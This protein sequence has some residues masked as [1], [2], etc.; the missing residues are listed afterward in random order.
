MT[1]RKVMEKS[2]ISSKKHNN[3]PQSK[4]LCL[5]VGMGLRTTRK[6]NPVQILHWI[7][8]NCH[9]DTSSD[10]EEKLG[11]QGPLQI[12]TQFVRQVCTTYTVLK[13]E[14]TLKQTNKQ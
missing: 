3:S 11:P 2:A 9:R 1:T 5:F 12:W 4:T 14:C 7:G 8:L 10:V 6:I 13:R